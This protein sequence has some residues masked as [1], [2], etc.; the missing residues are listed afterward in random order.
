MKKLIVFMFLIVLFGS[1]GQAQDDLESGSFK[2]SYKMSVQKSHHYDKSNNIYSNYKYN[3]SLDAPNNW[4][5]DM[6]VSQHTIFRTYQA[7]SA[8][9]M[10]INVIELEIEEG[11]KLANDIMEVYKYQKDRMDYP[12]KV[13]IPKHYNTKIEEFKVEKS[14]LNNQIALKRSFVYLVKEDDIEYLNKSVVFQVMIHNLTYTIGLDV[15]EMFYKLNP[16]Y[17]DGLFK[18]VKFLIDNKLLPKN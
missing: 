16:I 2:P 3:I 5:N 7:D 14:Y 12:Y 1:C 10:A 8:I 9:T 15:P 18:G 6:G 4:G 13:L 11:E 17:Y